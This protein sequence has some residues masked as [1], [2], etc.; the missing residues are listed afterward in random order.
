MSITNKNL[1]V[2]DKE[3]IKVEISRIKEK[4]EESF[5]DYHRAIDIQYKIANTTHIVDGIHL[6]VWEH[7][8]GSWTIRS[9]GEEIQREAELKRGK[10]DYVLILNMA[11][12]EDSAYDVGNDEKEALKEAIQWVVNGKRPKKGK[13][14]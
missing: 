5:K 3:A 11:D 6:E 8:K 1:R 12:K 2:W 4:Y 13:K 14:N 9:M 10:R 7:S